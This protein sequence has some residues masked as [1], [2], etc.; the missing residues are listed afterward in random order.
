MKPKH[1]T[2]K[3][4]FVFCLRVFT[5][6]Q[7]LV[8]V[9]A[10]LL[11]TGNYGYCQLPKDF[12]LSKF[13]NSAID[14]YLLHTPNSSASIIYLEMPSFDAEYSFHVTEY[15][16]HINLK[17]DFF[18]Q[19]YW[20][21]LLPHIFKYNN[22]DF[23]PEVSHSSV[24][25]SKRFKRKLEKMFS[26][27]INSKLSY[28]VP[29]E[30]YVDGTIY[31]FQIQNQENAVWQVHSP[32]QGTMAFKAV[33]VCSEIAQALKNNSFNERKAIKAIKAAGF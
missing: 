19:S 17:I 3:K 30:I 18:K 28:S 32:K 16:N 20:H 14:K 25:V 6:I 8:I 29:T 1:L 26:Q 2:I 23:E 12:N 33:E 7:L 31:L 11:L 9:M 21:Q 5:G 22:T 13:Y 4:A 10:I 24:I 27:T 15:N